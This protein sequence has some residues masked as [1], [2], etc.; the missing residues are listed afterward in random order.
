MTSK[1]KEQALGYLFIAPYLISF[2]AF[3]VIPVIVSGW[4]A[5]VRLD[6]TN[7]AQSE[8]IGF[9][10]FQDAFNDELFWKAAA[11][12]LHYVILMVPSTIILGTALALGMYRL[13]KGQD[14]VRAMIYLPAML[15]VAATGILWQWFFN[16][17]FG[18]FNYLIRKFGGQPIP[19]LT[20]GSFAM[21][22]IVIMSLWWTIGGTSVILLAALQQI[23]RMYFEAAALDG[24]TARQVF[25]RVM[26]P[27]LKPV[28][29][30][31]FV[32]TTIA[33]FQMFA[34]ALILTGGGPEFKTRGI[35]QYMFETAF[36]GY[37]FGY[38]A[39][40]SWLLFAAIAIFSILQ[41][42]TFRG[43]Y[44]G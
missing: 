43:G 20:D 25:T 44:D 2:V 24:A 36:N 19:W 17:E 22:S 39:A 42:R 11:A 33:S 1:A 18:L 13:Q 40:I 9:Q 5:F 23:P 29:L 4:L 21:P 10:N 27:L 30:F 16:N 26:I 14:L 15:N 35:V 41:A 28:L 6:L 32:T 34:Q 7:A 12:T 38:G 8:F 37:R 3:V 31:V